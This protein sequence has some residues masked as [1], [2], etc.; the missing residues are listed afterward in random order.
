MEAQ[1]SGVNSW[2]VVVL[3]FPPAPFSEAE[4]VPRSS[5]PPVLRETP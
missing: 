2:A 1:H 4:R 5:L 3:R